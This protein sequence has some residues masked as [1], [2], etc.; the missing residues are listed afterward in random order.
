MM[1]L[2]EYDGMWFG[3]HFV[4]PILVTVGHLRYAQTDTSSADQSTHNLTIKNG[5]LR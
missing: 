3:P 1:D 4:D 2:R 5:V